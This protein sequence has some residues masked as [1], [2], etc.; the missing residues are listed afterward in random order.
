[1]ATLPSTLHPSRTRW[2]WPTACCSTELQ[3]TLSHCRASLR[4]TS[5]HRREGL[6]WFPCSSPNRPTSTWAT[7][8]DETDKVWNWKVG[9]LLSCFNLMN[10][11]FYSWIQSG[12]TPLHLVAQ[13]GHVGIADILV[14]QG[15]SVYAATRVRLLHYFFLQ[16]GQQ[17]LESR[18]N[19]C[20][21]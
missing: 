20:S 21:H 13:E 2:R 16:Q 17:L 19:I 10:L 3:P 4:S 15:A 1:M 14:K 7:R 8:Q 12:L 5:P 9:I 18:A 11:Y 6:T